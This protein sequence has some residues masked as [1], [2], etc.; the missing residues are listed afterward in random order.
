MCRGL[1]GGQLLLVMACRSGDVGVSTAG[2]WAQVTHAGNDVRVKGMTR[3]Y[4]ARKLSLCMGEGVNR[5][6]RGSAEE[7]KAGHW[8]LREKDRPTAARPIVVGSG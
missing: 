1:R 8:A 4:Y 6:C 3:R 5:A 7:R 2:R